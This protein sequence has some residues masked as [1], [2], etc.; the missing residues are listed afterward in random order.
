MTVSLILSDITAHYGKTKVLEDL[1]LQIEEGELV[2]LLGAS[3][4]GKTTTLRLVAGFLQPTAGS[5]HLGGR[6]LTRLPAHT[7]DIG[8]VFQNYALF[9]HLSI[10]DNVA[11][12]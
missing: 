10:R 8:L 11:S 5:I 1:S 3:G 6:D 12:D 7:R 2:S 4:C 9:P